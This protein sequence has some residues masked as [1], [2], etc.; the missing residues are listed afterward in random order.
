SSQSRMVLFSVNQRP[1]RPATISDA[2]SG[3]PNGCTSP[4]ATSGAILSICSAI[5]SV[6]ATSETDTSTKA[7]AATRSG[8]IVDSPW[9][10]K[11]DRRALSGAE[12][13][14]YQQYVAHGADKGC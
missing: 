6:A 5:S 13:S 4:V 3:P 14:E 9:N 8:F 10:A 2:G 1:A 11:A 7:A 12:G